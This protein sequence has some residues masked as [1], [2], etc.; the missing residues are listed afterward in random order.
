MCTIAQGNMTDEDFVGHKHH[1][2]CK[3]SIRC[4]TAAAAT[5]G[6]K[7]HCAFGNQQQGVVWQLVA[8]AARR[9]SH[10]LKLSTV[11]IMVP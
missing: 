8:T 2:G 10:N 7:R 4:K 6:L 9:T 5:D 1:Q 11:A 3:T